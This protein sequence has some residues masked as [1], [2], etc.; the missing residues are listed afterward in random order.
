MGI[1]L[2]LDDTEEAGSSS[3]IKNA[4]GF[5][6]SICVINYAQN[7]VGGDDDKE[8]PRSAEATNSLGFSISIKNVL[9]NT[10]SESKQTQLNMTW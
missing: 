10:C 5:A 8:E 9:L 1:L 2:E 3:I 7:D 4:A 6:S